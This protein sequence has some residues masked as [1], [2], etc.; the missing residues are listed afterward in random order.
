MSG[1]DEAVF[2]EEQAG[3]EG[4]LWQLYRAQLVSY[5]VEHGDRRVVKYPRQLVAGRGEGHGVGPGLVGVLPHQ[6]TLGHLLAPAAA[7]QLLVN[8]L[9]VAEN[10]RDLKSAH[11]TANRQLLGCQ[12]IPRT[13][14][15]RGFLMCLLAHLSNTVELLEYRTKYNR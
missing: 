4:Q 10:T 5:R 1:Y 12:S 13:V 11:A 3:E 15:R 7:L 8:L 2:C 9:Q 14:E 6:T